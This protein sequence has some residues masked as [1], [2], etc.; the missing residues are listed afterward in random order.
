MRP[1]VILNSALSVDGRVGKSKEELVFSNRLEV[2]RVAELRGRVDGIMVGVETILENDPDL[3]AHEISA[4]KPV[5]II[6]DPKAVCPLNATI[7]GNDADT[8][9][10]VC[11]EA[12]KNRVEKLEKFNPEKVRVITAGLHA[13]S[14]DD[15]LWTLYREGVKKVVLEGSGQVTRRMLNEGLVNEIYIVIAP[16]M[17]G[18][19]ECFLTQD[20]D[21]KIQLL[22]EG[23]Q[24][25][26][27]VVVLHYIVK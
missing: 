13:I 5:Q 4:K 24:Q 9:I 16:I 6:I 10:A 20:L 7:L 12:P 17:I 22:L 2:N 18:R 14:L 21:R 8:I 11:S 3:L 15:L 27:D 25:F 26:G 1:Y 23:I 19:G